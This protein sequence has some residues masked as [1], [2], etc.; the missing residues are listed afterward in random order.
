MPPGREAG[1]LVD[2]LWAEDSVQ[3]QQLVRAALDELKLRTKV[4]FVEDGQALLDIVVAARPRLV[5]LDLQMPRLGGLET[6]D[7]LRQ[8]PATRELPVVV[9]TSSS[10][11]R[12][13][14]ECRRLQVAD[15][16]AKPM[17]FGAF[18]AAVDRVASFAR[19][20]RVKA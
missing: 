9:F 2:I 16:V 7:R 18:C 3:D 1:P 20:L 11:P 5:V 15:Y 8:S 4:A 6:L 19:P 12:D 17:E 13:V 14:A 10:H